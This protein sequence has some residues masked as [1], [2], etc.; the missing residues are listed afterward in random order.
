MPEPLH[1]AHKIAKSKAK[2]IEGMKEIEGNKKIEEKKEIEGT[3]E[4]NI[5]ENIRKNI[6]GNIER[7]KDIEMKKKSEDNQLQ[8]EILIAHHGN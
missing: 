4:G 5:E 7:K 3:I 8:E 2:D 1:I 6:E